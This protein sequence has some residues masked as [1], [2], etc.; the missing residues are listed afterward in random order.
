MVRIG[1]ANSIC[2]LNLVT[3]KVL[4]DLSGWAL[5]E[6][7]LGFLDHFLNQDTWYSLSIAFIA[8]F[9]FT[10]WIGILKV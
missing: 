2:L 9:G 5:Q 6:S 7:D 3:A 8:N 10:R 4:T 1:K